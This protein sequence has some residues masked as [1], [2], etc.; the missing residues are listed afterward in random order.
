M[1]RLFQ[2]LR[3]ALGLIPSKPV[4]KFSG[5][6]DT[7]F[8]YFREG[9]RVVVHGKTPSLT[10]P[11]RRGQ[12]TD[13]RR[14][15]LEH[16]SIIGQRVRD[17]VKAHKG[18]D[19]RLSLPTLDEYVS[20]TPRLVTPIY[21]A[22]A[23]LIVSLLDIHVTPPAEGS[24]EQPP[25]EILESGTGHGSLTLHLARAIQAA[26]SVPPPLPQKSQIQ[27]LQGRPIRPGTDVEKA[28]P[29]STSNT[30]QESPDE[31]AEQQTQ[32]QQWDTWRAHRRAI[33]HTVDVSPKF[34]AHAEKIVRGFR[35]GIYAG[36]VDFYVGHVE[37][38]IA[39][40]KKARASSSLLS[41]S[42]TVEPFLSYA[43]LDMPSAHLRIPHVSPI[44]KRDGILVVFMPSVTQ[45]GD[46]VDLIRRQKLPFILEK[47][48]ELGS[49]ISSGRLWDVRFAVKKSRADPSSWTEAADS[50][51]AE[52]DSSDA[53]VESVPAALEE[54]ARQEE[55]VLVCRPK[56][57]ARIV[58]GGFVGVWRR[59]EDSS[60]E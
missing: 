40:Q 27:Y 43:I 23:N 47:V 51:E 60:K 53:G 38:W 37:N 11:L 24:Q 3:R 52:E 31:S 4:P 16:D 13:V 2:S 22:D 1:A 55:S 42:P 39:V 56:V 28:D 12:K 10:K 35:R 25:L 33:I 48:V 34:S 15:V 6:I 50:A 18:P 9:D 17:L 49:G 14:G 57:G 29:K 46:C 36:N 45:V 44:L 30:A 26:N 19:Y 8:S 21:S 54:A 41:S 20:M 58:G 32:Q 7:N 59:I 5:S